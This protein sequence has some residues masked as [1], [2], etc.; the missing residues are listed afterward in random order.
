MAL[1]GDQWMGTKQKTERP[2]PKSIREIFE[3]LR[4]LTQSDGALH[5]ISRI[6]YRDWVVTVDVQEGR[7]ADDPE[8]RWST[9]K[10]NSNELMLL[11]GLMV[12]SE[13]DRTYSLETGED[14]FAAHA[15]H[16][17]REFHDRVLVDGAQSFNHETGEIVELAHSIGLMGREAIYYGADSFYLHQFLGFTR[18]RYR[19]DATWLLQN[20]GLSIR[21]MI[22]IAKF[23]V[24]RVNAQMTGV[25]HLMKEGRKF[26][27]G[28]LTSSLLMPSAPKPPRWHRFARRPQGLAYRSMQRMQ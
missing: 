18:Q 6:I 1:G 9:S 28:D 23:I 20:I 21:P 22:D 15:D 14:I 8:Y 10:L 19:D 25:G 11:L 5:E 26:S 3:E 2:K 24:D 7:V 17:L 4:T 13:S 27:H 16:L 12:Q